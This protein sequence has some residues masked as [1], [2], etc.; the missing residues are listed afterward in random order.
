MK[1]KKQWKCFHRKGSL[2]QKKKPTS[3]QINDVEQHVFPLHHVYCHMSETNTVLHEVRHGDHGLDHLMHQQKL[4]SI[5]QVSLSQI[6]VGARVDG[7]ALWGW[8]K[9]GK[10]SFHWL[11]WW[12]PKT[13]KVISL[14]FLFKKYQQ[15]ERRDIEWLIEQGFEVNCCLLAK[16]CYPHNL[17]LL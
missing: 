11:H 14:R 13:G 3:G 8:K 7:A 10:K 17:K 9:L 6:H 1:H 5:L 12:K 2:L 4:L 15:M 16:I